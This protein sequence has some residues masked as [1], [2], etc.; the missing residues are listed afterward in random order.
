MINKRLNLFETNSS[1][2][3]SIVVSNVDR[4]YDYDLPI[5]KDGILTVEFGEFG[6]GPDILKGPMKKISYYITDNCIGLGYY[7]EDNEDESEM[8]EKRIR[9]FKE[10]NMYKSLFKV[11]KKHHPELKDIKFTQH[12]GF[13][14]FGYVDHQSSGT[15]NE[16]DLEEL[17]FNESCIIIIDNDNC[18]HFADYE[19]PSIYVKGGHP[20]KN[21]EELW[22]L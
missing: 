22:D 9:D 14:P 2:S 3:H 12:E 1:S 18:E 19:E 10:T 7:L 20:M 16:G 13:Y 6:W 11:I 17:I 5:D 15:S 8:F 4:G 21:I